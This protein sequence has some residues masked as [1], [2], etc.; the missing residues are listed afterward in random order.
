MFHLL[1]ESFWKLQLE[2]SS[3]VSAWFCVRLPGNFLS[4]RMA[5]IEPPHST[6]TRMQPYL[7]ALAMSVS[8]CLVISVSP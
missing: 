4:S 6:S 7:V 2:A 1:I 3:T 8:V 5:E